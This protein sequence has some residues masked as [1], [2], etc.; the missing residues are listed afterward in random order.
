MEKYKLLGIAPYEGFKGY[1]LNAIEKRANVEAEVYSASLDEAV[2]LL[3]TL[4]LT[5]FDAIISRG[6]TGNMLKNETDLPLVNVEFSGYDLLRGL[7]LAQYS[8]YSKVAFVTYLDLRQNVRF[9]SELLELKTELILPPAPTSAE[10]MGELIGHL[11]R[12]EGVRLFIGDGAC[13]EFASAYGAE[14]ILITSGWESMEKAI[15]DAIEIIRHDRRHNRNQNFFRVLLEQS[16][17]PVAWMEANGQVLYSNLFHHEAPAEIHTHLQHLLPT[18]AEMKNASFLER[19]G[20]S[21]WKIQGKVVSFEGQTNY[22][23]TVRKSLS[24]GEKKAPCYDTILLKEAKDASSLILSNII[25]RDTWEKLQKWNKSKLPV[26]I[27]GG[28]GIG[29]TTFAYAVYAASKFANN[30]LISIDCGLLD[31]KALVRLFE[32]ERSPLF[33]NNYTI[34][35]KKV[36]L[37]PRDAQNKLSYY[38]TSTMLTSRNKIISTFSGSMQNMISGNLF[39]KEL[40][41]QLAAIPVP[42]PDLNE[43]TED[44]PAL[45]RSFLATINQE[46]P[47]QIVGFEPEAMQ[48][49]QAYPWEYGITQLN[50]VLKQ[51]VVATKHQ[52]INADDVTQV[53]S[54]STQANGFTPSHVQLDLSRTLDDISLDIIH[55]VLE[56]EKGNQSRTAKRLGISRSTLWKKLN[57]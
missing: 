55:L 32:D 25:L 42:L 49:L 56:E 4:D 26:M 37:L 51:L 23:F 30:P 6:R 19:I 7:K 14:T 9:L 46:M 31:S 13:T 41:H 43:R 50:L 1:L 17:T 24:S 11:Y 35:L 44:I 12:D 53:L 3:K 54:K 16:Q 18:V 45:C 2:S 40:Y 52:F 36:N 10:E 57:N 29:K 15:D 39:S 34:L 5:G 47:V 28:P 27:Y 20:E 8:P 48:M 33:E 21:D 38:M 22:L